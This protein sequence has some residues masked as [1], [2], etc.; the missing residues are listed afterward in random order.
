MAAEQHAALACSALTK[1]IQPNDGSR[2]T[3]GET[4]ALLAAAGTCDDIRLCCLRLLRA[5]AARIE[6]N[7]AAA[8]EF[9]RTGVGTALTAISDWLDTARDEQGCS[10]QLR[11]AIDGA[12]AL[13]DMVAAAGSNKTLALQHGATGALLATLERTP[14]TGLQTEMCIQACRALGNLCYGWDV[15]P[16]K[17]AIGPR[18]AAIVVA[19]TQR[20][21]Q[22]D[23]GGA[24]LFRWHAHALRNLAVR[25]TPMQAAIADAGGIRALCLGLR[26]YVASA[27]V[28]EVGCKALAFII[29]DHEASQASAASEGA[30]ELSTAALAEHAGDAAVVEAAL[31]L[32][33][34]TVGSGSGAA[35]RAAR[36]VQSGAHL[37][38]LATTQAL[39]QPTTGAKQ[40][41]AP[42]NKPGDDVDESSEVVGALLGQPATWRAL[43]SSTLWLLASLMSLILSALPGLPETPSCRTAMQ[44]VS[45]GS[46]AV[47][48][49]GHGLH[50]IFTTEAGLQAQRRAKVKEEVAACLRLLGEAQHDR[51]S[52]HTPCTTSAANCT[53]SAAEAVAEVRVGGGGAAACPLT[54]D[55]TA[56][57]GS[58]G[59]VTP[60]LADAETNSM[61]Q[62]RRETVIAECGERDTIGVTSP[63]KEEPQPPLDGHPSREEHAMKGNLGPGAGTLAPP[64]SVEMED[65]RGSGDTST[66]SSVGR[67]DDASSSPGLGI[68]EVDLACCVAVL[69]VLS[70]DVAQYSAPRFRALR[71]A[72]GPLH[73]LLHARQ[74]DIGEYERKKK[75]R[76]EEAGRRARQA[77]LDRHHRDTTRLRS[78]RISRLKQLCE[79]GSDGPSLAIE[80]DGTNEGGEGASGSLSYLCQVPDG[81]VR[82]EQA[83]AIDGSGRQGRLPANPPE[84]AAVASTSVSSVDL[85][86]DGDLGEDGPELFKSRQCY[87]CKARF[88]SLHHFYAQ[89]CPKCAA[90][91]YRMRHASADLSGRIALLTGSRVKIGFEIGLK[92]LRAGAMLIA[93]TRFPADAAARYAAAP[94]FD[95]WRH[96]LQLHAVDL[97][98]VAAL[99]G[100]CAFLISTLPRLDIVVNNACQTVRR[101]ASYYSHLL[102]AEVAMEAAVRKASAGEPRQLAPNP[103]GSAQSHDELA[104]AGGAE[105]R[106][107]VGAD[108]AVGLL[109]LFSQQAQRAQRHAEVSASA[110]AGEGGEGS[111]SVDLPSPALLSQLKLTSE[112]HAPLAAGDGGS[113]T[114]PAGRLDVNGQQIDLRTSNSWLLKLEDVST[115]ELVEVFAINTLAPFLLNSRLQPLMVDTASMDSPLGALAPQHT[116]AASTNGSAFIVNVSAME[117][118]FYRHKTANH[119]HTNMAKAALNMMTRTSAAELATCHRIYMTAVDTGWINDENPRDK[120]ARNAAVHHFQTPLDEVDAAARVLHPVFDGV[121]TGSPVFGVFLKDFVETEW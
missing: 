86:A 96:R 13:A 12:A 91:N 5:E 63:P 111:V 54:T 44:A 11:M 58:D 17:E 107:A 37:S 14:Q 23:A 28:Q 20:A 109:P 121:S 50:R 6:K 51:R 49:E 57:Q 108:R 43:A 7:H 84:T 97:R 10:N 21:A 87:T 29:K 85:G 47:E 66:S 61:R 104:V 90:L 69:N 25:S 32:L 116:D 99:E 41:A 114:L 8:V 46:V 71:C 81:A 100:F 22:P 83:V 70:K 24:S 93:T 34:F 40:T 73:K 113:G 119:P 64:N 4:A 56:E 55:T 1:C 48:L 52:Q 67:V 38:A 77:E 105:S 110:G 36:A 89:L 94:D 42:H 78:G 74:R 35:A 9:G 80:A 68:S 118:K 19:A 31:T 120:A 112:D 26:A 65:A 117:G 15:D 39:L 103:G 30:L 102:E 60:K 88:T 18:G 115:P 79:E 95:E 76:Q 75:L 62:E 72:L 45:R 33:C 106:L 53:I 98:D 16:I 3:P 27:R 92:L 101:P 2:L 59:R 82:E